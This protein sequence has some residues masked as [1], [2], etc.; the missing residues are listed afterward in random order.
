MSNIK[1]SNFL[2][3]LDWENDIFEDFDGNYDED[4]AGKVLVYLFK[5]MKEILLFN[6]KQVRSGDSFIDTIVR[7]LINQIIRMRGTNTVSDEQIAKMRLEGLSSIEISNTLKSSGIEIS[8]SGIRMK[9][10]WKN[11]QKYI[12]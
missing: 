4:Q 11:Y 12:K 10:G 3:N 2:I 7:G 5:S 9:D 8:S 1:A 6:G